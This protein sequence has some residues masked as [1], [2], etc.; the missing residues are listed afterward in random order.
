MRNFRISAIIIGT[1]LWNFV[2]SSCTTTSIQSFYPKSSDSVCKIE[3]LTLPDD[4]LIV[5]NEKG[6]KY[7]SLQNAITGETINSIK[8]VKNLSEIKRVDDELSSLISEKNVI[9]L[10][11]MRTGENVQFVDNS[12]SYNVFSRTVSGIVQS[13]E[14]PAEPVKYSFNDLKTDLMRSNFPLYE[15]ITVKLN[16]ITE[17]RLKE[18]S[19]SFLGYIGIIIGVILLIIL[20]AKY[21]DSSEDSS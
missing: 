21:P 16:T 6:G 8:I 7:D 19:I 18:T 10:I 3:K 14:Y 15:Q 9:T 5:F 11:K 12:T 20:K 2:L 1:V 4:N 17:I 13:V